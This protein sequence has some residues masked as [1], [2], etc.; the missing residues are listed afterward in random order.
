MAGDSTTTSGLAMGSCTS[1]RLMNGRRHDRHRRHLASGHARVRT[2]AWRGAG[3]VDR[4]RRCGGSRR[5]GVAGLGSRLRRGVGRSSV[6]PAYPARVS[7]LDRGWSTLLVTDDIGPKTKLA[8]SASPGCA[9]SVPMSRSATGSSP[10]RRRARRAHPRAS[11]GVRPPGVVRGRAGRV[12]HVRRQHRHRV[13]VPLV[14]GAAESAAARAGADP[15][16]RQRRRT[17]GRC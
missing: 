10:R 7:R 15:R 8:S 13:P 1:R 6:D 2:S 4:Y 12:A 3:T 9:T 16:V 5:S 11:L 14:R 17:G